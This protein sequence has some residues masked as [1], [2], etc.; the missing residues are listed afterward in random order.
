MSAQADGREQSSGARSLQ[1]R[2][3]P[4]LGS[5]RGSRP[6]AWSCSACNGNAPRQT[7]PACPTHPNECAYLGGAHRQAVLGIGGGGDGDVAGRPHG[8]DLVAVVACR[9]HRQELRVVP[10]VLVHLHGETKGRVMPEG[11]A[12]AGTERAEPRS[13]QSALRERALPRRKPHL[14]CQA[15]VIDGVRTPGV[16][17]RG[18]WQHNR[19]LLSPLAWM[20]AA[21][22][23]GMRHA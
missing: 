4:H 16:C 18:Q 15:V 20:P 2:Y 10:A 9:N 17:S 13:L 12:Q 6:L 8:G 22:Q 11:C 7:P 23:P 19:V 1:C 3:L 21:C 14:G 5:P